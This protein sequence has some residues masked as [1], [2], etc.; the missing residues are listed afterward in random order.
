MAEIKEFTGYHGTSEESAAQ[1]IKSK[2]LP[3]ENHDDWLG[4]G[5]YFFIDGISCPINNAKE[6]AINQAWDKNNKA[7]KYARYSIIKTTVKV[8]EAKLL[9]LTT[10]AG[11]DG[12]NQV[13][14]HLIHVHR[15]SFQKRREY[16][17]DDRKI[18]NMAISMMKVDVLISNLYI[19][20]KI[21]RI[22]NINSNIPNVTV[23]LV[24]NH[25]ECIDVSSMSEVKTGEIQ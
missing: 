15:K 2:F 10:P 24:A 16:A 23:M 22:K 3:S 9:D 13:R 18:C 8:S 12:F 5:V 21:Q 11:L 7:N 17:D 1:I 14:N 4:Y 20:T 19:K 25:E 6:W